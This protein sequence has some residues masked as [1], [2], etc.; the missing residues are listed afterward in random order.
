MIRN[1]KLLNYSL[2]NYYI[3]LTENNIICFIVFK[4]YLKNSYFATR[5]ELY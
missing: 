4:S 5:V 2:K 3:L 1:S